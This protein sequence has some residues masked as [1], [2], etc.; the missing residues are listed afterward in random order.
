MH[1]RIKR[2]ALTNH[3]YQNRMAEQVIRF[4]VGLSVQVW[5]LTGRNPENKQPRT[6]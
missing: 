2:N 4:F 3:T 5:L 6:Y 1:R